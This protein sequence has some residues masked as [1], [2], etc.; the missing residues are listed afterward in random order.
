MRIKLF[1]LAVAIAA[2][3]PSGM[4]VAQQQG[5]TPE[6]W[7]LEKCIEYAQTHN[8]QLLQ[9]QITVANSEQQISADEG[10]LLPSLSAA[11]NQNVS[12][13][14]WSQSFTNISNGTLT[15]TSSDVNYNGTYGLTAQWTVWNGGRNRKTLARS[16]MARNQAEIDVDAT[17]DDLK[18]QIAQLYVQILYQAE[19]VKVNEKI[20]ESSIVLRDRAREMYRVGSLAKADVAQTEAQV[21]QDEYNVVNARTQLDNYKL[22][23]KSLL[24]ITGPEPFEVATPSISDDDVMLMLPSAGDVYAT[25]VASRPEISYTKLGIDMA[26]MDIDIA[27]RGYYP[28]LSLS[29]AINTSN[30]SGMDDSFGSQL[31]RNLSNSVGLTVSVPI[32]DN[33][34][35]KTNVAKARLQRESALLELEAQKAQLYSDIEGFWLN[36]VNAQ[37]QYAAAIV[38]TAAMQE[39]Y[40]LVSEQFE[41]GLKDIVD[42]I[43]AKNNLLQADQQL[44]QSKY[45]AVLNRAMLNFYAG[46]PLSI[47]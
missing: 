19:A 36:A 1:K 40:N 41:V 26:E 6:A 44:L 29:G 42:V 47:N 5:P 30:S 46:E 17:I 38:N 15:S 33:R 32:F 11:T 22:Q 24:Q 12:W 37:R 9:K 4:A 10:A 13:R 23:L 20:Y 25:A 39:S 3:L 21:S 27:K 31:K 35:N 8:I 45:M 7:S 2:T 34:Q 28:S 18:E 14:P 16:R 43:T